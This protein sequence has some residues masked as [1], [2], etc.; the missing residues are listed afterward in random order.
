MS[1][2]S[3]SIKPSLYDAVFRLIVA[4]DRLDDF[5]RRIETQ[6]L[7]LDQEATRLEI[8]RQKKET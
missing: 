2:W 4:D 1:P 7:R 6:A 3:C 8:A 5:T